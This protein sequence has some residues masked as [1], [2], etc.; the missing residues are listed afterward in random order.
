[1]RVECNH[2]RVAVEFC[3]QLF[4]PLEKGLVA[5]MDPIKVSDCYRR[6]FEFALDGIDSVKHLHDIETPSWK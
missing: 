5:F 2:D 4:Y 3:G 1:M 6:V